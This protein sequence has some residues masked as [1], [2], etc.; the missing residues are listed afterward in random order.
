MA[1]TFRDIER[2]HEAKYKLNEELQFK[3]Q[4]RRNRLL[5]AWAAERLGLTGT[6]AED[7]ARGLVRYNLEVPGGDP[8]VDKIVGDFAS[9][10][11]RLPPKEVVAAFERFQHQAIE[12]ITAD[13][14]LP[15]DADHVQIG[16]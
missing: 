2:G 14:P 8:V 6:R 15:L 9:A 7:Y 5:G 16:G 1:D 10:R 4:C 11:V 3:A 13:Y 12:Q